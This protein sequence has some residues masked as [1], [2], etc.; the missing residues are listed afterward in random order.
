MKTKLF[1]VSLFLTIL[2]YAQIPTNGLIAQYDFDSG[3]T[4]VDTANGQNFTQT[5]NALTMVADRFGNNDAISLNGD[6]LTRPDITLDKSVSYSFWINTT[7]HT[8]RYKTIIDNGERTGGTVNYN[9]TE[10]GHHIELV[11]GKIDVHV[12]MAQANSNIPVSIATLGNKF[13][14]DGIWHHIVVRIDAYSSGGPK[15]RIMIYVDG[16][17]VAERI[18]VLPSLVSGAINTT[19]DLVV[20]TNRNKTLPVNSNYIDKIDDINIY[21]RGLSHQEILNIGLNNNYCFTP[22]NSIISVQNITETTADI[23]LDASATGIYELA[24]HKKKRTFC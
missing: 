18:N 1:L 12:E 10:K 5:G 24:Y 19:G 9:G 14:A 16:V 3:A 15:G 7:T 13:I 20:G 4:L 17:K 2:T 21:N 23:T 8:N 6:N 22:D 11:N